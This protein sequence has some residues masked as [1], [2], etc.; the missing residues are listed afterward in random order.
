M[1]TA[2]MLIC[3]VLWV[4]LDDSD[5]TLQPQ[6]PYSLRGLGYLGTQLRS[7]ILRWVGFRGLRRGSFIE[8]Q[9]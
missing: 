2:T 1:D 4:L 9:A 3:V 7:S 6:L 8:L 5:P